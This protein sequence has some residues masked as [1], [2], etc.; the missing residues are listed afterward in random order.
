MARRWNK[1][2]EN[3]FRHELTNLYVKENKT[4]GQIA[5]IL[6]VSESTVFQRLGRLG[7]ESQP[8]LKDNYLRKPKYI[9]LPRNYSEDLAEF[10][11]IMLGDGH[12]SHFQVVVTL[13][14]KEELYIE[15]VSSL[16]ERIFRSKPKISIRATGYRDVYLGSTLATSWLFKEGLVSDKVKAQVDIPEWIFTKSKFMERFLRGFFDTDGSVYKLKYGIQISL[17]NHSNPLL[18]SLHKMLFALRYKP[19]EIS[20]HRIYLTKIKD[21]ERFFSEI[22]PKNPKHIRRFEQFILMRR[23][24]S[25]YSRGL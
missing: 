7:I 12:V 1:S 2:E 9:Y 11:G 25:G 8:H 22:Q 16:I 5:I 15:Y 10:F 23:S 3:K 19:S 21:L 17:T 6:G 13:G 20:T 14:S 18:L 4:I 24:D